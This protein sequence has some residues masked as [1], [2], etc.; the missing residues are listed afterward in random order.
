MASRIIAGHPF[1]IHNGFFI[2]EEP[3]ISECQISCYPEFSVF[4]AD[5]AA[6]QQS[7]FICCR[8]LSVESRFLC[9]VCQLHQRVQVCA[10]VCTLRFL[11][12]I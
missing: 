7:L 2:V 4:V 5:I 11:Y 6:Y 12:I 10:A 9:V 3:G 1:L 8:G